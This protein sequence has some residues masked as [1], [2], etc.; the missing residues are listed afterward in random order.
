METFFLKVKKT[1]FLNGV[2]ESPNPTPGPTWPFAASVYY[3]LKFKTS[4][5][6][7]LGRMKIMSTRYLIGSWANSVINAE[8]TSLKAVIITYSAV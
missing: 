8:V 6:Q 4:C 3:L 5:L 2:T 1:V 7:L